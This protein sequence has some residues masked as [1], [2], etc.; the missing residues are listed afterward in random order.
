[1]SDANNNDPLVTRQEFCQQARFTVK[2]LQRLERKGEAPAAVEILPGRRVYR[3]SAI[4]QWFLARTRTGA[5]PAGKVPT[6]ARRGG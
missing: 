6:Q 3:Q 1:M 5:R 2:T 4:N